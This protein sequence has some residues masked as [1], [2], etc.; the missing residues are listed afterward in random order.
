MDGYVV[1]STKNVLAKLHK[2]MGE[3]DRLEKAGKNQAFNYNYVTEAQV[4][5]L[6][7][8]LFTKHKMAFTYDADIVSVEP[9]PKGGQLITTVRLTYA[10]H[11][12]ETGE[13]ITGVCVGQGADSTDKGVYKAIT[14]AVKY[15][16]LKT[17]LIPT[18]D[19]PE[20]DSKGAKPRKKTH[21]EIFP[22]D[23]DPLEDED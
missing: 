7:K 18:G 10:F 14:G 13:K 15:I 9:T 8:K 16:F 23:V 4:A 17:F 3:V 12:V 21:K 22:R 2:V 20:D 11:D 5:Q 19:D 6:F 1:E